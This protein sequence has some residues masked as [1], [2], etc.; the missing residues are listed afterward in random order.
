[1]TGKGQTKPFTQS[2]EA[3]KRWVLAHYKKHGRNKEVNL[4]IK[5][6]LS[7]P[8]RVKVAYGVTLNMGDYEYARID[9]GVELPCYP[10]EVDEAFKEANEV[11]GEELHK[12]IK[13][14]KEIYKGKK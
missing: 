13:I 14:F 6:F 3:G 10:A 1:M 12:S 9:V 5:T 2:T 11:A 8:A 7:T 4:E